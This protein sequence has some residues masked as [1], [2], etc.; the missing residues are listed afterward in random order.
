[1]LSILFKEES[2]IWNVSLSSSMCVYVSVCIHMYLLEARLYICIHVSYMCI[3]ICKHICKYTC[4]LS[5]SINSFNRKLFKGSLSL[6]NLFFSKD[7]WKVHFTC[8]C[9]SYWF[10][11]NKASYLIQV[12]TNKISL[13]LFHSCF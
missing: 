10:D 2:L 13:L 6:I 7:H 1:M 11:T 8:K 9:A 12:A 3:Y 4:S 5:M